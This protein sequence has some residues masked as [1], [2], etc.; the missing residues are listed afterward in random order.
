[1]GEI[2]RCHDD[3]SPKKFPN[4]AIIHQNIGQ[5]AILQ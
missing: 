3:I 5:L 4:I 1:M 2:E